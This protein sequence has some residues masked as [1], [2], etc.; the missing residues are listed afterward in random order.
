MNR[1]YNQFYNSLEKKKIVL[2]GSV[3]VGATGAPTINATTS[4]G[5]TSIVRNSAGNYTLTLAD[6]YVALFNVKCTLKLASGSPAVIGC[7]LRSETVVSTKTIVIEFLNASFAATDPASG[8]TMLLEIV[9]NG[10]TIP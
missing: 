10:T 6:K 7:V 5:I 3:A 2:Y 8:C 4:K 9:L 1:L